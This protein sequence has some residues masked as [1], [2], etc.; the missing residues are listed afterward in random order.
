[1]RFSIIV[2]TRNRQALLDRCLAA[3]QRLDFPS[4]DF[5]VLV[6]DDGSVPTA[7]PVLSAYMEALPLR[8]FTTNGW[9]PARARNL[10]LRQAIGDYAVFTDDDCT[11]DPDWLQAY[12]EIFKKRPFAGLGG[13]IVDSSEN[14]LCGRASQLIVTFLYEYFGERH[15]LSFFCSNNFAFPRRHLLE[16]GGFNESFPLPGAEDRDLCARWRRQRELHF[17]PSAVV[18]HRQALNFRGFCQQQYRYG[19]GAYHYWLGRRQE[20]ASGNRLEGLKFYRAMFAYPFQH[21]SFL[22]AFALFLLV[23]V[24]QG[25]TALG[26][27]RECLRSNAQSCLGTNP[28]AE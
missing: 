22:R 15:E 2:P 26:Y 6:V 24:S 3:I 28:E 25:A 21:E 13:R 10:A 18:V 20:G 12:D 19:Q 8:V 23:A 27:F 7:D 16:L 1:M 11:P 5:E 9:G 14:G 17:V 4:T